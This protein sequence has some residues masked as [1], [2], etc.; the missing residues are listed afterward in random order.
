VPVTLVI[1]E[2]GHAL[3]AYVR[4]DDE[5]MSHAWHGPVWFEWEVTLTA[6][7]PRLYEEG[8]HTQLLTLGGTAESGRTYPRSYAWQYGAPV[9][10]NSARL[11]NPGTA[12]APAWAIYTGPLT[13][14]RL[15]DGTN[16][17][18]LAPLGVG[19][20]VTVATESLMAVAPGGATRASYILGGSAPLTVPP[21]SVGMWSLYGSG[22][23]TV[24]L[25]WRAAW[26]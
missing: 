16:T 2:D 7:D 15:T 9:L 18:R 6:G 19:Q 17:I 5:A 24:E 13:E 8:W 23:G 14:T 12:E 1:G 10:G 25:Q 20:Q 11:E 21:G 22:T 26:I 3:S 4:A